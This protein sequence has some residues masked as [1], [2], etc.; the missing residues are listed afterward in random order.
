[1][2]LLISYPKRELSSLVPSVVV[3]YLFFPAVASTRYTQFSALGGAIFLI[4][5]RVVKFLHHH[6]H[7]HILP[8]DVIS[9]EK[10][11]TS[12]KSIT[13]ASKCA[14][15]LKP[16]TQTCRVKAI[17]SHLVRRQRRTEGHLSLLPPHQ[18]KVKKAASRFSQSATFYDKKFYAKLKQSV[19][20]I[21]TFCT[22]YTQNSQ[23]PCKENARQ[24]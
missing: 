7:H 5:I 19:A 1:M 2:R 9:Q 14:I 21:C 10:T 11:A 17:F 24:H 4:H 20:K 6:H 3:L 8:S 15:P 22:V 18:V 16:N 23:S 12:S 13:K